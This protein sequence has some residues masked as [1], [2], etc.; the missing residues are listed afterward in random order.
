M[1]D[2]HVWGEC[3]FILE[4]LREHLLSV[5]AVERWVPD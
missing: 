1:G 5:L 4:H 3:E 2:L